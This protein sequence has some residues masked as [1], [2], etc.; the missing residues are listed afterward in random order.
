MEWQANSI[1]PRILMPDWATRYIAD[2]WLRKYDRLSPNLR[3]ER[4]ID[5]LSQHFEVT[6]QLAKIR[7]EELGYEDAKSAFAFYETKQYAISFENAVREISRNH[8]FR[9]T[10][11]SGVYAYVDNC[12]IIRDSRYIQREDD[13][14]LHLTPYAKRHMDECCLSFASRRITR[15]MQYGM[16]RNNA[17]DE[18]FIPGSGIS[19]AELAKRTNAVSGIMNGLPSSFTDTLKAHMKRKKITSEMLAERCLMSNAKIS[20]IRRDCNEGVS[21]RTVIALCI[22]LRL[23]PSLAEDLV[24]KAG[25]SFNGSMEHIAFQTLLFCMTNS[26][27]YE[28]ND[29]LVEMK[30]PPLGNDQK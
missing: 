13:G 2:G 29:Y 17:R 24:R 6:R 11:S 25:Y 30:M 5:R 19:A 16:L 18:E 23:H 4:T 26:S 7:M 20:R 9:R 10:L 3:M 15:G 27:I 14:I 12:F 8:D 1:A 22:G 21:L 28:C